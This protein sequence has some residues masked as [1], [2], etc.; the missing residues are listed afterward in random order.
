MSVRI[1]IADDSKMIRR[2]LRS[3]LEVNPNWQV[4][5][6]TIDGREAVQKTK[7]LIPDLII[8]DLAMPVMNGLHAAREISQL[9]PSV[10]IVLYSMYAT[11]QVE[12]EAKKVGI[13]AVVSKTEAHR[14]LMPTIETVLAEALPS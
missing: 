2:N 12:L 6:E 9:L 7:Q 13:R 10:P 3:F 1:L 11:P 5:D 14:L 8:L 4:C